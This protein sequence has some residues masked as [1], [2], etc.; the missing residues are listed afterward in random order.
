MPPWVLAYAQ[1]DGAH[2]V[3][4]RLQSWWVCWGDESILLGGH[5]LGLGFDDYE[6]ALAY[7]RECEE[8]LLEGQ[9]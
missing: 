7:F 1:Y 4:H 5:P 2:L 8:R 3:L 6:P 9:L